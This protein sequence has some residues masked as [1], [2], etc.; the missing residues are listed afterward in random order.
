MKTL[1][2]KLDLKKVL[3]KIDIRKWDLKKLRIGNLGPVETFVGFQRQGL[4]LI[5]DFDSG[6]ER[7]PR[8]S[9]TL[10]LKWTEVLVICIVMIILALGV[11]F[12]AQLAGTRLISIWAPAHISIM[13]GAIG[14]AALII[15]SLLAW[16]KKKQLF[17]YGVSEIV[18]GIF[19]AFEIGLALFPNRELSQFIALASAMYVV[20]RG[21]G[22][23]LDALEKEIDFE[24]LKLETEQKE[25]PELRPPSILAAGR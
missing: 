18:F 4:S 2:A 23:L 9:A 21:A 6:L 5:G 22:N 7:L 24:R 25:S 1:L 13:A 17:V 20:S 12:R 16:W 8:F 10:L 19:S 11:H 15:G 14:A 3:T